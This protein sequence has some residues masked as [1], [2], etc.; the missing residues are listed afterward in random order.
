[1]AN[2]LFNVNII[3]PLKTLYAGRI[4]SLVAPAETGYVGILANHAPMVTTLGS[5]KI[6]VREGSGESKVFTY[7]GKGFLEVLN[8]EVTLLLELGAA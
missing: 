8:N 4:V 1:M 6:I 3:S 5:G 2:N 7:N